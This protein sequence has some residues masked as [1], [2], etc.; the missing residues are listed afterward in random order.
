MHQLN[1]TYC[2]SI[3]LVTDYSAGDVV[4]RNCGLCVCGKII[5]SE[6]EWRNYADDDRKASGSGIRASECSDSGIFHSMISGGT[7]SERKMLT[8]LHLKSNYCSKELAVLDNMT[9]LGE[10]CFKLGLNEK[11]M[12]KF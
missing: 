3:D 8:K 7:A 10:I 2:K 4:C 1:C 6:A 5:E 12:V 9:K 11:I